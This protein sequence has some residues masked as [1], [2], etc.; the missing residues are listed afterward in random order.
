M[1]RADL[2]NLAV[3]ATVAEHLSFRRAG[4][5]LGISPSAV[6]HAIRGL[7]ERL[8]VP[9][10]ARTTRSVALTT[11][12]ER[13]LEGLGP[14]FSGIDM[15]L[16]AVAALRDR[17][18]GPLRLTVPRS[19]AQLVLTPYVA[20]F[21]AAFPDVVLDVD[22]NDRFVDLVSSGFDAGIRIGESLERDM[23][24]TP[25]GPPLRFAA[26]AAPSYFVN[27]KVP[28]SPSELSGHRCIRR[29]Q[30]SG[31]FYHWEFDREGASL[32]VEVDGPLI[33]NDDQL[34]LEAAL[35]GAGLALLFEG[36]VAPYIEAGRLVRVLEAWC[37][38]FPGFFLY[39]PSR[40][41]MRPPLRAFID[42]VRGNVL[43]GASR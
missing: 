13:L 20:P 21:S 30:P 25:L 41:L 17:P 5:V 18:V 23:V 19:A 43:C 22:I 31:N 9:L 12:G 37:E 6:S 40:R 24:V 28:H 2:S 14:A 33:F 32:E 26:V 4:R 10:L 16:E 8:H 34:V 38:P 35:A 27:H 7:E 3:F 36:H 29:R 15:A 1:E 11:A 42:F 39:Y